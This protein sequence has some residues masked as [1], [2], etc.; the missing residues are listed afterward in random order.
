MRPV[1]ERQQAEAKTEPRRLKAEAIATQLLAAKIAAR[2]Q[3]VP[4]TR[5]GEMRW[6]QGFS[7]DG[8]VVRVGLKPT[9]YFLEQKYPE[10]K[11]ARERF[12]QSLRQS[13][14]QWQRLSPERPLPFELKQPPPFWTGK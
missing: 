5:L 4:S 8:I 13:R 9:T 6:P 7:E 3:F 12:E 1:L 11:E 14:E 2:V 10:I